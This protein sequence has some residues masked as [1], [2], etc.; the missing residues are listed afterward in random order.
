MQHPYGNR[1]KVSKGN[2]RGQPRKTQPNKLEK[3]FSR[4]LAGN[5]DERL[6]NKAGRSHFPRGG[7]LRELTIERE[8]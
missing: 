7:L 3:F 4:V 2:V 5:A 1:R 6:R 8:T